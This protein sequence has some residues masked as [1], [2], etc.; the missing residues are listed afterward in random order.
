VIAD[1]VLFPLVFL[2]SALLYVDQEARV[3]TR[4]AEAAALA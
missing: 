1:V 4:G 3:R 2:G